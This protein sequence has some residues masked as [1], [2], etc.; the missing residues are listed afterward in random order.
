VGAVT[1]AAVDLLPFVVSLIAGVAIPNVVDFVTHSTAPWWV[2][3]AVATVLSAFAGAITTTVWQAGSDWKIYVLNI[4]AA[5]IAT[6]AAHSAGASQLVQD[7]T[8]SFGLFKTNPR[9]DVSNKHEA[10]PAVFPDVTEAP[11]SHVVLPPASAEPVPA[12]GGVSRLGPPVASLEGEL[13]P[14][15]SSVPAPLVPEPRL[16]PSPLGPTSRPGGR[17]LLD[18]D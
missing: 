10:Q 7:V 15:S 13:P 16:G 11:E 12:G 14:P 6:F 5:F 9:T 2:K 17:G 1:L 8:G 18:E 4:F 3:S